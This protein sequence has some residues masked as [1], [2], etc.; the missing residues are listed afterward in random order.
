MN[1][2]RETMFQFV[3]LRDSAKMYDRKV[4]RL[5]KHMS[6]LVENNHSVERNLDKLE[7]TVIDIDAKIMTTTKIHVEK[8][9]ELVDLQSAR[10]NILRKQW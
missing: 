4:Q 7:Q 1:A 10:S 6:N 2:K 5:K 9:E 8:K 3:T